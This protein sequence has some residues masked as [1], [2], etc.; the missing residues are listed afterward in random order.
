[1][2]LIFPHPA[3][4]SHYWVN[5]TTIICSALAVSRLL[6]KLPMEH[7]DWTNKVANV[8]PI[9]VADGETREDCTKGPFIYYTIIALQC[10]YIDY[11]SSASQRSITAFQVEINLTSCDTAQCSNI[12]VQCGNATQLWCSIYGL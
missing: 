9:Q 6:I 11:I 10:Q 5:V 12:S 3:I 2:H 1:M 7:M 8:L 4:V